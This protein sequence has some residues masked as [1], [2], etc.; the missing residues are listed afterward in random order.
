MFEAFFGDWA[1]YCRSSTEPSPDEDG[2]VSTVYSGFT[3]SIGKGREILIRETVKGEVGR[4]E[5]PIAWGR[6]FFD[7]IE[8]LRGKIGVDLRPVIEHLVDAV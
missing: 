6:D 4:A 2:L 3:A 5:E 8:I 7:P 1:A